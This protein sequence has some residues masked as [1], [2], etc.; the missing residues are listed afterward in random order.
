MSSE[1]AVH[2]DGLGKCYHVYDRPEDR[3]KQILARGRRR[4][5][6][7]F[8]ALRDV[9]LRLPVGGTLGVVGRNGSGKSTLLQCIAGTLTPTEGTVA[10]RGRVAALLELGTGFNF[11]FTGRENVFL[12]GAVLG[13]SQAEIGER[14]DDIARFADLGPFIDQP[15][16]VYSSG[17][18]VRLAFAVATAVRPDVLILDEALAVGDARFQLACHERITR[19]LDD[20]M[21][22]LFVSH[23]GNAVKRL[24]ERALVLEHGRVAFDGSPNDA[25]NAYSRILF[26]RDAPPRPAARRAAA[27][28]GAD[29]PAAHAGAATLPK[30]YRFGSGKGHITSVVLIDE[31]RGAPALAFE[32]GAPVTV[33]CTVEVDADVAQPIF[34][35]RIKNERG[36]EVYGTNTLFQT[37]VLAP[38]AAGEQALVEFAQEMVLMPGAYFLSVSFVELVGDE[39]VPIDRRYDVLE[40]KVTPVDRSFGIANLRTRIAVQRT[41]AAP[42]PALAVGR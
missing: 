35:L 4:Y 16:K 10:V 37:Q 3:L 2:A 30:E 33:R 22:L 14:F 26:E 1:L 34:A 42:P 38:F 12:N 6:R 19:M 7:E 23:D 15:V 31:G 8:W 25:L 24:C 32:T 29:A 9:S 5:Y 13:L 28:E 41:P 27:V 36:M 11:E 18:V 40:F 21:T 17:M 20:G 39:V